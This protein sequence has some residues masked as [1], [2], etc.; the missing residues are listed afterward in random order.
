MGNSDPGIIHLRGILMHSLFAHAVD[1]R[2]K[3]IASIN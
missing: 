3:N 1:N 2:N